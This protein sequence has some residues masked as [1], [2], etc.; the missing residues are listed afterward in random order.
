MKR[1]IKTETIRIRFTKEEKKEIA[2]TANHHGMSVSAMLR[3]FWHR[4]KHLIIGE[5][6][7]S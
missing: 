5:R 3:W 2:K 4:N 7:C 1:N 6:K